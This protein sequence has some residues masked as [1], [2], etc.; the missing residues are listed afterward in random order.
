MEIGPIEWSDIDSV[1][2]FDKL[3]PR[4]FGLQRTKGIKLQVNNRSKYLQMAKQKDTGK[5]VSLK[6]LALSFLPYGKIIIGQSEVGADIQATYEVIRRE[7]KRS[8]T[9]NDT[10]H[11]TDNSGKLF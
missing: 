3:V 6:L 10:P 9:Q 8:Q 4:T 5:F 11:W 7:H 2:Y 1:T